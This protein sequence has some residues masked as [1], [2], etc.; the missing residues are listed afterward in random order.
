MALTVSPSQPFQATAGQD[1]DLLSASTEYT[2]TQ[3][4]KFLRMSERHVNNLLNAGSIAFREESGQ[5][6]IRQDCLQKYEEDLERRHVAF[7]EFVRMNQEM[8]LYDD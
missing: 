8:G 2:V 3:A 1:V 7:D 4:A 6:L 5:R